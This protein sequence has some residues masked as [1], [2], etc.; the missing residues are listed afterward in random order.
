VIC[1]RQLLGSK[2]RSQLGPGMVGPGPGRPGR[3]C[4][5]KLE[6]RFV[7]V[8]RTRIPGCKTL[9]SSRIFDLFPS[10]RLAVFKVSIQARRI[11]SD[12]EGVAGSSTASMPPLFRV[13]LQ[14]SRCHGHGH[15]VTEVAVKH[16]QRHGSH[17]SHGS[18]LIATDH[19][20]ADS[21][22]GRPG[23]PSSNPPPKG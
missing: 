2:T 17:G 14:Q 15:G 19:G 5:D 3:A 6:C 18:P 23:P 12:S 1:W 10:L 13:S 11:D 16:S 22:G 9:K 8:T 21:D 20:S 4:H 7:T